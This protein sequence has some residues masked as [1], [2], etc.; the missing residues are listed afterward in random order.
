MTQQQAA[1]AHASTPW[2]CCVRA[3]LQLFP[4]DGAAAK[5]PPPVLWQAAACWQRFL[6]QPRMEHGVQHGFGQQPGVHAERHA[7][8]AVRVRPAPEED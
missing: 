1:S 8:A 4:A 3:V 2:P 6:N 5:Q 7:D